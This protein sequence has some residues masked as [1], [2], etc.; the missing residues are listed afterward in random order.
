MKLPAHEGAPPGHPPQVVI[1][2][3]K[4]EQEFESGKVAGPRILI[5]SHG[6]RGPGPVETLMAALATCSAT[7][8]VEI[9]AKR[10]TP[11]E[12]LEVETVGTRVGATPRKLKHV[13][14]RFRITGKGIDRANAERAIDLAVNKYCS[15]RESL[16]PTIPVEWE[17]TLSE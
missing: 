5:D 9:L 6:K 14:L 3:W 7:D 12:K 13:L 8:V 4:G 17:L 11:V 15:V 2:T 1:T 16:D 10:R